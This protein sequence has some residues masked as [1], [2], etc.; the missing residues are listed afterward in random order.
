[1]TAAIRADQASEP[2]TVA[3]RAPT[4]APATSRHPNELVLRIT[5]AMSTDERVLVRLVDGREFVGRVTRRT[6]DGLGAR[7]R[8]GGRAGRAARDHHRAT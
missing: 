1:V 7:Q 2:M 3:R 5:A 6:A 8:P 4:L